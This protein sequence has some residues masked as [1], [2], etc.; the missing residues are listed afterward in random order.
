MTPPAAEPFAL[1]K[2]LE[3]LPKP[4]AEQKQSRIL[5]EIP[6][7]RADGLRGTTSHRGGGI[8]LIQNSPDFTSPLLIAPLQPAQ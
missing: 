7:V 4:F 2:R 1:P 5:I 3:A 8:A 6:P